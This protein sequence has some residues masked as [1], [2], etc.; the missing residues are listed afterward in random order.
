M[1]L[2]KTEA[3]DDEAVEMLTLNFT[4]VTTFGNS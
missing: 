2:L 4:N 3:I 1:C